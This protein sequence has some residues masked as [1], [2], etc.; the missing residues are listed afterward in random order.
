MQP[1]VWGSAG[2]QTQGRRSAASI[3]L[4]F[5]QLLLGYLVI[6]I[7]TCL[8]A[9]PGAAIM[10]FP[11]IMMVRHHGPEAGP[12]LLA[13]LGLIV[14]MIP[15]IYLN[16]SWIFSLPLIVD[17]Q[18]EFWPAMGASRKMVGSIGGWFS[19]SWWCA[20]CSTSP[21]FWPAAWEFFSPCPSCSAL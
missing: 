9:L 17:R 14:A 21:G 8:A 15:A 6:V 2:L 18:M 3:R 1:A 12:I 10:A 20:D 13:V 16:I 4:A 5:G 11:I 19:A 7:L